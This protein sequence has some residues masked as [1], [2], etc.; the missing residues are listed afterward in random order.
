MTIEEIF[1]KIGSHM[2]EGLMYHDEMA[3]MYDFIALY[4]YA[5][6]QNYHYVEESEGYRQLSHYYTSHYYKLMVKENIDDP[7]IIPDSWYK[8]S[9]M[10]IDTGTKRQ[11]VKELMNKWV[12]WEKSTKKLYQEMCQELHTIGE[13]AAAQYLEKYIEDVTKELSHAEQKLIQLETIGYDIIIIA[14]EQEDLY[15]KYTKKLRW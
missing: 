11:L 6:E 9:T 10:S 8:Y 13:I 5:Q 1:N 15:K 3:K 2:I 7:K 14:T 12:D 4:G